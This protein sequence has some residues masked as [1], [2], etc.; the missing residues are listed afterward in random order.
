MI[1]N[2]LMAVSVILTVSAA[3]LWPVSHWWYP[4][5]YDTI[6]TRP[7]VGYWCGYAL[8]DGDL[9]IQWDSPKPPAIA[10]VGVMTTP[11][12]GF[13]TLDGQRVQ[14]VPVADTSTPYSSP[15]S[16]SGST[17]VPTVRRFY[18]G[19]TTLELTLL[20][21]KLEYDRVTRAAYIGT[22]LPMLA[23]LFAFFSL[24]L[25]LQRP[26]RRR[27]R[28]KHGLCME[29]GYDLTGNLSGVCPECGTEAPKPPTAA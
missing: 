18:G 5:W 16:D 24:M 12:S 26:L 1:R 15:P 17:P 23:F 9:V 7:L 20:G 11:G 4:S 19:D 29:C 14:I 10:P 22:P 2:T 25:G 3:V 28:C 8:V 27:R 6:Q 21:W 13:L